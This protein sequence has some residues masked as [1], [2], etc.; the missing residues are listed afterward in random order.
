MR[1]ALY[2]AALLALAMLSSPD[3]VR[4]ALATSA[5]ALFEATPFLMAGIAAARLLRWPHATA[6]LGC[7]CTSGPSARSLPA[8]AATWLVL[9]PV[10]AV[11]R[12]GAAVLVAR[13]L[14]GG[15]RQADCPR[16]P[17]LLGELST[18]LPPALLAGATMQ[19]CNTFDPARLPPALGAAAGAMLGFATAPCGL[20][21]V[22]VAGAL[23]VRAPIAAVGFLCVAGILDLRALQRRR[24]PADARDALSYL[25]LAF[26]LAIVAFRRGDALVHPAMAP[27]LAA[28]A[29]LALIGAAVHRRRQAA[30][31]RCAPALMLIGALIGAPAP[32]YRA[33][34]TTLSDIFPG[35][36]LTFTGT[37]ARD[38]AA[39]ALVRYAITCCRADA[40]PIVVRLDRA[41]R[42][43][44]GNWLRV[45]GRIES[46]GGELRLVP[47]SIERVAAPTDPFVYR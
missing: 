25:L 10:V 43:R 21:A 40:A 26:A 38:G 47:R 14:G 46:I 11:A 27:V 33:T 37:L 42:Y 17:D 19:F 6:Y 4:D 36:H 15:R 16:A 30:S 45:D 2:A 44:A 31:H 1:I 3:S 12:L 5:S 9:G 29:G 35:E 32:E 34:E 18:L 41:P 23:R 39:S 7:G 13:W 8:T 22:A 20:G 24:H 28:S